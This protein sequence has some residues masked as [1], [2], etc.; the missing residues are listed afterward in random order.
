M[1]ASEPH[2][3]QSPSAPPA[4]LG[5]LLTQLQNLVAT[6]RSERG[7]P[8]DRE[9]TP[10]SLIPYMLEEAYEVIE[11]IEDEDPKALKEELGDLLLHVVFQSRIAEEQ[12]QFTLSHSL[13]SIIHKLI[14]RHPHVFGEAQVQGTARSPAALGN[15]KTTRK[16]QSFF[17]R[18]HPAHAAGPYPRP[19]GAGKSGCGG[20]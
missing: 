1:A 20:F 5:D 13:E 14:R 7:C 17:A 2:A 8:W 9:Q 11:S 3:P 6:L 19:P 16:R 10:K 12:Q 4:P 18:W 15:G